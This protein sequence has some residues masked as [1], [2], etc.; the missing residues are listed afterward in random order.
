M[1]SWPMTEESPVKPRS[2]KGELRT[3]MAAEVMTAHQRG[4]VGATALRSAD[5]YGPGVLASAFGDRVFPNLIAGKKAQVMGSASTPHSFAYIEDVGRAAAALGTREEALG[6]V[7][8]APHAPALTQGAMVEKAGRALGAQPRFSVLSPFTM[9]LG[10]LFISAAREG[11]E[12]MYEFTDP[13]VVDSSRIEGA[14]GL[15][16]TPVDDAMART[17]DWYKARS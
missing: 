1:C 9:R 15:Q 6:A 2:R 4:D 11:V 14:F 13:F 5:Y 17:A 8:I 3:R 10:G 16:A 7:W 12:M